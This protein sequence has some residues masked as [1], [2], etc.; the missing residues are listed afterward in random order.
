[1]HCWLVNTG[2]TGG[3]YG[4][5]NRMPIKATRALLAAAMNGGLDDAEYRTD[6]HFGFAVPKAV[7]GVDAKIL[8][9][10]ETWTD[11][12]AYDAQARKLVVHVREKLRHLQGPRRN[13]RHGRQ[14]ANGTGRGVGRALIR[15][16][17]TFSHHR[18]A[19]ACQDGMR[20]CR[21][22]RMRA[23]HACSTQINCESACESPTSNSMQLWGRPSSLVALLA[24][25]AAGCA[26]AEA[27]LLPTL[28]VCFK[29]IGKA[30]GQPPSGFFR[31]GHPGIWKTPSMDHVLARRCPWE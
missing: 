7:E 10:R 8:N 14:P 24:E 29:Q 13:R 30:L 21:Q 5:G 19:V 2:W 27:G 1:M 15:P 31:S 25:I 9:P 12:K 23:L 18:F 28:Q 26:D 6:P 17:G 22:A 16:L 11:R 3:A 20:S 4:V